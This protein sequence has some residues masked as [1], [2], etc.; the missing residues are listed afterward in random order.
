MDEQQVQ[1]DIESMVN[2]LKIHKPE[3][4]TT[5]YAAAMLDFMQTKLHELALNDPEELLNLYETYQ[6]QDTDK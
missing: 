4:A 5:E 3:N 2:Y 6:K 1:K